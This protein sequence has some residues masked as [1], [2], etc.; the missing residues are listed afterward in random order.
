[1]PP[2]SQALTRD[3]FLVWNG[4]VEFTRHHPSLVLALP[5]IIVNIQIQ[6]AYIYPEAENTSIIIRWI[7]PMVIHE[8]TKINNTL[9]MNL[10]LNKYNKHSYTINR[11]SGEYYFLKL[12]SYN[13]AGDDYELL[14]YPY[15][16]LEKFESYGILQEE[17]FN[18]TIKPKQSKSFSWAEAL[19][20]CNSVNATLPEFYSKKEQDEL[21]AIIKSADMFPIEAVFIGMNR[22]PKVMPKKNKTM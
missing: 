1:M 16:L 8:K 17:D 9:F 20:L 14:K 13:N 19:S 2:K 10:K 22:I 6:N 3:Q 21:I 12:M 18:C 5:G 11:E 4:T 7:E 15:F